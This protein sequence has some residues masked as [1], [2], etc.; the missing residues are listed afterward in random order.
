VPSLTR[1]RVCVF[2]FCWALPARPFSGL[3]PTGLMSICYCLYFLDSPN[4]EIQVPAFISPR[5]RVT[6]LHPW[7]LVEVEVKLRPTVSRPVRLG[8]LPLLEQVTRCYI[9]LSGN[10]F[11]YLSCRAPSL[12]RGRV[13]NLQCNDASSISSYIATDGLSASSSWCRALSCRAPV[14]NVT[15]H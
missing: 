13:C 15:G 6:Q 3:S 5:K 2:R 4:L 12:M 10:Y 1:S 11:F 9:Y 7:A 14:L 8:V